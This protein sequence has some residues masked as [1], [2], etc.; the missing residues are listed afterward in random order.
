MAV[1]KGVLVKWQTQ[2]IVPRGMRKG[3]AK[4]AA[5]EQLMVR[6]RRFVRWSAQKYLRQFQ[7]LDVGDPIS[8]RKAAISNNQ[9][10]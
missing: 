8:L 5:Q 7:S 3:Q 4:D 6:A 9:K 1:V 2:N 10:K